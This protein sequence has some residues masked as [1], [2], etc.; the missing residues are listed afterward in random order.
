MREDKKVNLKK[1]NSRIF[2]YAVIVN[3]IDDYNDYTIYCGI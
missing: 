1:T 2:C 3:F